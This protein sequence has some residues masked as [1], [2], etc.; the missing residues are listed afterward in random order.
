[1]KTRFYFRTLL[2]LCCLFSAIGCSKED[3]APLCEM[4]NTG[5]IAVENT[6]SN[7]SL[8]VFFD[9][10]GTIPVN[11]TGELNI[12]TGE[13]ASLQKPAGPRNLK[14]NLIISNC[15]GERCSVSSSRLEEKNV[16][17]TA[18]EEVNIIY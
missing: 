5:T 18:C 14:V 13:K 9:R 8:Q 16:D 6:R 15:N 4:N 17:L 11:Q 3:S 12:A 1:M 10:T 7:G 2:L